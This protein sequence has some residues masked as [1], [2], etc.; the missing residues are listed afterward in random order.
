[1]DIYDLT[2]M[3][4]VA[5]AAT[6]TTELVKRALSLTGH[7]VLLVVVLASAGWTY[8]AIQLFGTLSGE[9]L[10]LGLSVLIASLGA[11]GNYEAIV[12]LMATIGKAISRAAP[13]LLIGSM[14]ALGGCS[15]AG[16]DR[17]RFDAMAAPVAEYQANHPAQA[18]SYADLM[19]A[20]EQSIIAREKLWGAK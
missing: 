7:W 8:A 14:V 18:Q 5:G 4:G 16:P 12:P 11:I 20:W 19:T 3:A 2:T 9:P 6:A 10:P 15:A 1:M 17:A 13:V